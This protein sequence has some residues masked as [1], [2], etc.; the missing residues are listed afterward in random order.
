MKIY[1]AIDGPQK[2]A[3][4]TYNIFSLKKPSVNCFLVII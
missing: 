3:E 2:V 4:Y 1:L